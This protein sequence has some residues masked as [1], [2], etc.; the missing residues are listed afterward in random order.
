MVSIELYCQFINVQFRAQNLPGRSGQRGQD[1]HPVPVPDERGGAH[2]A[3]HRQQR[4]G[5]GLE[6]HPL[7]HVGPGRAGVPAHCLE[8]LLLQHGVHPAGG[9]QHRQGAPLHHQGG[10]PQDAAVRRAVQGLRPR[11]CQQT[12]TPN[13]LTVLLVTFL[14]L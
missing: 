1:D 6:Q 2:L 5:G 4:G 12:G 10:A 14:T 7:H 3:H 11:I 13:I 9:G 8:H